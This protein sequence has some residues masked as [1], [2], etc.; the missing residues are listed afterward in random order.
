MDRTAYAY[1]SRK[2]VQEAMVRAAR[3]REVAGVFASGGY[4]SRP[5]IIGNP[6]DIMAMVRKGAIEFHCSIERWKNPMSIRPENYNDL[7]EGW[8][9]ILDLDCEDTEHGKEAAK[10][11]LWA[12]SEHGIKNVSI[13]FT[14]G[15]GFHMGLPWE[16]F[17]K[18]INFEELAPRFPELARIVADYLREFA[19]EKL[20]KNL[21]ERWSW[22]EMA[23]VAGV[24]VEDV[25]GGDGNINP[26]KIVDIDPILISPRHLF[27]MPYSLNKKNMLVSVPFDIS[28]ID[29]FEKSWAK[30]ENVKTDMGFLDRFEENE[31]EMLFFRALEWHEK[32]RKDEGEKAPREITYELSR[33]VPEKHF[34]ACIKNILKG[35]SDGRKRSMFI[36]TSFLRAVK[37]DWERIEARLLEWNENNQPPLSGAIIKSHVRNHMRKPDVLPPNCDKGGWYADVGVCE[38]GECK[39][40]KNPATYIIRTFSKKKKKRRKKK[41]EIIDNSILPKDAFS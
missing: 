11:L 12:L 33:A 41:M 16:A 10:A 35:M 32:S 37:W 18:T 5:D 6:R 21:R 1:Y 34:P 3:G 23:D 15:T 14:G 27:R 25:I 36:L 22:E 7:R 2:D 8:D 19:R 40:F 30:P 31:A 39:K 24:K 28:D 20:I 29:R 13:K 38:P 4:S 17:P 9:I 26:W